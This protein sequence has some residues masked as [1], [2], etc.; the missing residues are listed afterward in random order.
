MRKLSAPVAHYAT[1]RLTQIRDNFISSDDWKD[2]LSHA[3]EYPCQGSAKRWLQA[4]NG[5][6]V[7]TL[8]LSVYLDGAELAGGVAGSLWAPIGRTVDASRATYATLDGSR[9]DYSDLSVIHESENI[10]VAYGNSSD[11]QIS[12]IVYKS[13]D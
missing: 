1:K 12:L 7:D 6:S 5:K 2:A 3:A 4:H 11:G 10:L 9:R 13:R 8:Q